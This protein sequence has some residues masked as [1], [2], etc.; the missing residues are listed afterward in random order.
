MKCPVCKNDLWHI[1]KNE[2]FCLVCDRGWIEDGQP[3]DD[4]TRYD[5]VDDGEA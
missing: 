3:E 2:V 1:N 4:V 5:E